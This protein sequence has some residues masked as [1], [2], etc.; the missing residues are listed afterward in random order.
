MVSELDIIDNMYLVARAF[1]Q[2]DTGRRIIVPDEDEAVKKGSP[3]VVG[4]GV[5][6][7]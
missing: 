4:H 2:R 5:Y 7:F 6:L 3:C 1:E